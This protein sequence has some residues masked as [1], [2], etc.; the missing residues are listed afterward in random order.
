MTELFKEPTEFAHEVET[1]LSPLQKFVVNE[2]EPKRD[3]LN[4]WGLPTAHSKLLLGAARL[5]RLRFKKIEGTKTPNFTLTRSGRVIGGVYGDYTTLVSEHA[6]RAARSRELT[7]Q[8][9]ALSEIPSL[10][11]KTFHISQVNS[12]ASF[13][14]RLKR[15]VSVAPSSPT[16]SGG[17]TEVVTTP[18]ELTEAWDRAA[19]ACS[20]LKAVQQQVDVQVFLPWIPIRVFVVGE[21]AVATLAR[22]P[23]YVVGDGTHTTR[24][25]VAK[26]LK[27]RNSCQFLDPVKKSAVEEMRTERSLDPE[28]V[29]APGTVRLLNAGRHGQTGAGWSIDV[30][31]QI[32]PDLA[33]LA[34]NAT[35]AFPGL[36]ASAVDILTPSL[37]TSQQAVVSSIEP[38]ADLR[39]FR[40]PAYGRPRFPNRAILARIDSLERR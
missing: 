15:P 29:L 38:G 23:L 36:G 10:V 19:Q 24:Q 4:T 37:G 22:A 1:H 3:E 11:G 2:L 27:R 39:E 35:W 21:E 30:T 32:S 26:E 16:Y 13:L 34:I 12:A 6:M 9:L 33:D 31:N 7:R 20:G 25:L 5:R 18:V 17:A 28:G 8:C 40:Y 14:D